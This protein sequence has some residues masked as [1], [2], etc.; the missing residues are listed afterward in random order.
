MSACSFLP[1]ECLPAALLEA[2]SRPG[3]ELDVAQVGNFGMPQ[4]G[5]SDTDLLQF[6]EV[7]KR[8]FVTADRKSFPN[9]LATHFQQGRHTYGVFLIAPRNPWHLIR[10]DIV[11]VAQCSTAEEWI[12]QTVVL[13]CFT[14]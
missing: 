7:E 10:N 4:K 14:A 5:S 12:D 9:H 13:P 1:D 6:C 2:L 3:V 11:L 8:I